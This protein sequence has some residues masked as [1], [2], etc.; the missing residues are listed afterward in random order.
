[1]VSYAR[2]RCEDVEFSAEDAGRTEFEFLCQVIEAAIEAGAGTV[3]IPDTVG[4]TT[5][6]EFSRIIAGFEEG[7]P[8]H[9][10]R[11]HFGPLPQRPRPGHRQHP[12]RAAGRRAA[13]RSH[14]QRHRRARR[15]HR[16]RRSRDGPPHPGSALRTRH[17]HRHPPHQPNLEAGQ[18]GLGNARP[19]QQG[20]RRRQRLRPRGRH[21][22]GRGPQ[23]TGNLRDHEAGVG[24]GCPV[25]A[26][27]RQALRTARVLRPGSPN[28][29]MP[30]TTRPWTTPSSGSRPWPTARRPSPTPT[31]WRW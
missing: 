3:N 11:R 27:A 2:E 20:H 13:G 26:G 4:Y 22:P 29:A 17:R 8:R 5:P 12:G 23:E 25:A 19:T 6:A 21:P 9:R 16:S 15:Q 18:R 1:M 30:S 28:S 31:S 10:Q 24:R 14:H 7:G